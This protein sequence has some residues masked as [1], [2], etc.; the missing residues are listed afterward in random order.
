LT[1]GWVPR[2]FRKSLPP[3]PQVYAGPDG[4]LWDAADLIGRLD[5]SIGRHT[6]Q[7]LA[8]DYLDAPHDPD[9]DRRHWRAVSEL[10]RLSRVAFGDAA[11]T[12]RQAA[13]LLLTFLCWA[14]VIPRP[15]WYD[16]V[17]SRV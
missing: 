15:P 10:A 16:E 13:C 11:G 2:I 3:P 6:L 14:D 8:S 7:R 17:V 9:G 4:K 1:V 12:G 5:A